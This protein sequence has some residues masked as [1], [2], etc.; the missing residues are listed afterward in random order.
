MNLEE[1]TLVDT[2]L[3]TL[4]DTLKLIPFL[5]LTYLLMEFIEHKTSDKAEHIIKK[6]GRFGPVLGGLLGIV[7]QCGFSASAASLYSGHLISLGTMVAIFL[8]TS[9]EMLPIF[10]SEQVS[11]SVIGKILGV[12]AATAIILGLIVDIVIHIAKKDKK[13]VEIHSICEHDHCHCEEGILKSAIHHSA[14][15]TAFIFIISL[16]LN[17][18]IYF[19]GEENLGK[20]FVDI[21]VLGCGV[22]SLVG[23]IPNCAASVV[24]TELFLNGVISTAAMI[25]GLL[26]GCGIGLLVLFRTNKNFKENLAIT[27]LMYLLGVGAGVI[28][29]LIGFIIPV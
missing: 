8:S 29:E 6:A 17:F 4:L 13:E 9:D 22:A 21:P 16:I 11:P 15:I 26:T 2:L 20:L 24:I 27:L 19:I 18:V 1:Q 12:K 25:S 14:H 7:P 5:F 28:F 23:L 3:D 10:L